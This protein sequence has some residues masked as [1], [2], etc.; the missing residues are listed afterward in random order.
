MKNFFN[1][2]VLLGIGLALLILDLQYPDINLQKGFATFFAAAFCY[3]FLKVLLDEFIVRKIKTAKTRYSLRKLSSVLY[4]VF[5]IFVVLRIWSPN[6]QALLVTYGLVAAGVAISLQDFFKNVVG[7][8][9]IFATNTYQVGDRIEINGKFG[10]VIDIDIFSTSLLEIRE[11]IQG[12]QAT[13]RIVT[14]P[15]GQVLSANIHHYTKDH[16]FIWDEIMIPIT[17]QS[18]WE[19]AITL[20]KD[21]VTKETAAI[22]KEAES[23]FSALE[24][25]YYVSKRNVEPDVFLLPTDNW[26]AFHI[27]YIAKVRE[28]R[29]LHNKL[30]Q[31]IL[32][33]IQS[34]DNI[35]I[36]S[37]TVEIVGMPK[38]KLNK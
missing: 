33:A 19:Q 34:N 2:L 7:G 25:K 9:I 12:D 21:I 30:V 22:T 27:R 26:I 4:F 28:R 3:L 23:E 24:R 6:A 15:N 11:W 37:S 29:I 35:K 38:L 1:F 36:A 32:K 14:V 13:G 20:I 10:D 18:D 16:S 31:L 17:Y 8:I 5:L